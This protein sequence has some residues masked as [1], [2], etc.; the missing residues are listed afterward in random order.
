MSIIDTYGELD[1][2]QKEKIEIIENPLQ[3][4]HSS[5]SMFRKLTQ[6]IIRKDN[7]WKDET[8]L[9]VEHIYECALKIFEGKE[10][11]KLDHKQSPD[12]LDTLSRTQSND[13][14]G[15]FLSALLNKTSM[16]ALVVDDFAHLIQLGY[17]LDTKKTLV[18]GKNVFLSATEYV[19]KFAEGNILNY[20][21]YYCYLSNKAKSGIHINNGR[22]AWNFGKE[23]EAGMFIDNLGD[24]SDFHRNEKTWAI[25]KDKLFLGDKTVSFYM[26]RI[27]DIYVQDK[28]IFD[29]IKKTLTKLDFTKNPS[30]EVVLKE[31]KKFDNDAFK[32]ELLKAYAEM[33]VKFLESRIAYCKE[34]AE[35]DIK[36]LKSDLEGELK[37]LENFS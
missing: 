10:H 11:I 17:K 2:E 15:L 30:Y 33:N 6:N 12:I 16:E 20:T 14:T 32:Q 35:E 22:S 9:N 13:G 31:L 29:N 25:S 26:P 19:G 28:S 1:L 36:K 34:R 24:F 4:I 18:V 27:N 21:N 3:V 5:Y 8:N 23:A 7:W 37:Q